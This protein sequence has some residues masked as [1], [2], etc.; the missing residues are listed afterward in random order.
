MR[1]DCGK[2]KVT[3]CERQLRTVTPNPSPHHHNINV[4]TSACSKSARIIA[5]RGIKRVKVQS[6][7]QSCWPRAGSTTPTKPLCGTI[8]TSL[9]GRHSREILVGAPRATFHAA[10]GALS[11][12]VNRA[13]ASCQRRGRQ[14]MSSRLGESTQRQSN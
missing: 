10:L 14:A 12:K 3:C 5:T 13:V 1:Q 4:S 6:P 11:A 7:L 8:L 2:G 9:K